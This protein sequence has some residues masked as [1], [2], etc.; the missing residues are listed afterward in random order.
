M[1]KGNWSDCAVNNGPA[2]LVGKCDCGGLELAN[3]ARDRPVPVP[4]ALSGLVMWRG[5]WKTICHMQKTRK[6]ASRQALL[7]ERVRFELTVRLRAHR[8][9]RPARSATPAPLRVRPARGPGRALVAVDQRRGKYTVSYRPTVKRLA[10]QSP[11][12]S[13]LPMAK[14]RTKEDF[15]GRTAQQSFCAACHGTG[16]D[17]FQPMSN[18]PSDR[19]PHSAHRLPV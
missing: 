4:I 8:F 2:L 10:V 13:W 18:E 9:S 5:V 1:T 16:H 15:E 14:I 19:D 12:A 6:L 3:D 7:A 11:I 17:A